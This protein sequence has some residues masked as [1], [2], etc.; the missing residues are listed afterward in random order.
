MN[1][2]LENLQHDSAPSNYVS[3]LGHAPRTK[4]K[5]SDADSLRSVSSVRSVMSS[6]STLWSNL[7]LANSAAKA[8]KRIAEHREDI[9]YL[10]SCFTKIPA[11][12][13]SPDHRARLV[14]GYEEFPF[15]TAVPLF[16]FKNVSAL[17]IC[18]LDFRQFHG[19]DR[20][21]EQLR[22]LTVKRANVDDP[23]DLLQNIVLDDMEKRRKRSFKTNLPQTPSTPGA[24]W[25]ANSPKARQIELA[26]TM[27]APN[28]PLIDNR[29]G[30]KSSP[31]NIILDRAGSSDGK[32][33]SPQQRQ[34]SNSP[35]RPPSSRHGSLPK[36]HTRSGSLKYRRG[37]GSSGSS[38]EMTPRHSSTDLLAL[39]ILSSNKWRFLR[40]L[41][42][43]ENGLTGLT[44]LSLA[45]IAGTLQS[46]DL[47]GNLFTEVPDALAS[48]THLRA[49]NL[50]NC[51]I[52]SLQ[53]LSRNPLP[54][55]TTLNLRSNRL[56][57]LAGIE[58]LL[59]LERVD[60]RENRL[61]DPTELA[62]LTG[63]PDIVDLYV[64][65]NP[66]TRT[67]SNYRVAIF[68][69][70]RSTPGHMEDVTIDTFGPLYNE[71]KSLVD[72]VPEP[73]NVPVVKPPPEDEEEDEP[74]PAS[75]GAPTEAELRDLALQN[76][77]QQP[78]RYGHRRSTSDMG[79]QS[80]RRKRKAPRRRIVELSQDSPTRTSP[81]QQIIAEVTPVPITPRTP[82]DDSDQ[83]KTPE[84]TPTFHTAP[85]KQPIPLSQQPRPTM[86]A[87]PFDSPTPVP[88]K[89]RDPSDDDDDNDDEPAMDS[90]KDLGHSEVYRQKIEALKQD[91]GPN[92]LSALN[93]DRRV[94]EQ[95]MRNR[96]FSPASRTSTIKADNTNNRG[97]SVGG[98]TL[99]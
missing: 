14:A 13:L 72:R 77:N 30:S 81:S 39:G 41:S 10:Y 82:T 46:F 5:Q 37:S 42:L 88:P 8:E 45:P 9:K 97:V 33:A 36:H 61:R 32:Q 54:A 76:A 73:A 19:W 89:I 90:P 67:H 20:L 78:A 49:L 17:E 11:L 2:R 87:A 4:G 64:L 29:R 79:P 60:L 44:V 84:A 83:P 96:S 94:S 31:Q 55:I 95:P 34:R 47:S 51:M 22:S 28:S 3:F 48:L 12:K 40:H 1:V 86:V 92:W 26:R 24:P 27:S 6:M 16:A 52:E 43:A 50:S 91:L 18:D 70:F 69:L 66:F 99:G 21:A 85:T 93:E 80:M 7:T 35:A 25:P 58:R 38:H 23:I 62:R 15:D 75:S 68:N 98:R 59:S 71:K 65:R 53:S 56:L 63:I 74:Q 57:N